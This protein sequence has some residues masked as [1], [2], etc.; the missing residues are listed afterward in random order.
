MYL[1]VQKSSGGEDDGAADDVCADFSHNAG[2]GVAV[3]YERLDVMLA[4]KIN[5]R[6]LDANRGFPFQ[7]VAE[8]K[9]G[10]KWV[11]WLTQIELSDKPFKGYWEQRGYDND[12]DVK[13]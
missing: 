4:A 3:E 5:G 6:T 11:K 13:K 7:V 8:A 1:A 10:Y 2:V 12:A 9:L